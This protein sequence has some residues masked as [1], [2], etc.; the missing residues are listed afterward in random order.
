VL[1]SSCIPWD[2]HYSQH[3]TPYTHAIIATGWDSSIQSF[4]CTDSWYEYQEKQLPIN[5]WVGE[6]IPVVTFSVVGKEPAA[7]VHNLLRQSLNNF[8]SQSGVNDSFSSMRTLAE[9]LLSM[10]LNAEIAGYPPLPPP[11]GSPISN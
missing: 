9:D 10:D 3:E 4:I 2:T 5:D 6:S 11:F 7:D 8:E 1:K